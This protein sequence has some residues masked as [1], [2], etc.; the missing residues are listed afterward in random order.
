MTNKLLLTLLTVMSFFFT[1][2]G[3]AQNKMAD[4]EFNMSINGE[5]LVFKGGK[6]CAFK[7][8]STT[9]TTFVLN[10]NGMMDIN[11][12]IVPESAFIINV[13]RNGNKAVLT[14]KGGTAWTALEVTIPANKSVVIDENGS[15]TR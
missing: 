14:S 3:Q 2:E 4:F 11:E 13:H 5:K 8:L 1:K 6:E 15:Y 9:S 7:K 10:E 12:A